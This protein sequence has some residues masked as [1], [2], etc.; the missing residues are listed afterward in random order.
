MLPDLRFVLGASLAIAMLAVAGF[1]LA[2]STQLLHEARV[3]SVESTQSL[4]YAGQAEDN[5][6][7]DPN[8]ALRFAK[9]LGRQDEPA[10]PL[11]LPK[12]AEPIPAPPPMPEEPTPPDRIEASIAGDRSADPAPAPALDPAE[13]ESPAH[14]EAAKPPEP[15]AATPASPPTEPERVAN[16]PAA[17]PAADIRKDEDTPPAAGNAAENAPPA[18]KPVHHKPRPKVARAPRPGEQGF[19]NPGFPTNNTQWPSYGSSW[20]TLPGTKKKT[21]T[22]A[23]W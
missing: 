11:R 16:A 13:K 1:G 7:Y 6:F 14:S 18:A 19:Q 4:A 17:P 20:G 3:S 8:S 9:G 5:P 10:A 15:S 23:G 22:V 2:I 21:G 12:A